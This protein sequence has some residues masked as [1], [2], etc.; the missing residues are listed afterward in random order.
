MWCES[1][2]PHVQRAWKIFA[3]ESKDDEEDMDYVE[4][5]INSLGQEFDPNMEILEFS[6]M[7]GTT[8]T[9]E[10][11]KVPEPVELNSFEFF[12][13]ALSYFEGEA[14]GQLSSEEQ[15]PATP[16][17]SLNSRIEINAIKTMV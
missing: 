5:I 7:I 11:E 15:S 8:E 16:V 3:S 10:E 4:K 6:E 9:V 14:R 12:A 1:K 2:N 17:E 13:Q